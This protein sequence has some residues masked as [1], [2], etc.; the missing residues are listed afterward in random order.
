MQVNKPKEFLVDLII[1]GKQK[2]KV[3]K[4]DQ[5]LLDIQHSFFSLNFDGLNEP[6]KELH[7][8]DDVDALLFG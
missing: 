3:L 6:N 7:Y 5:L 1:P 2:K 4:Y 8:Y